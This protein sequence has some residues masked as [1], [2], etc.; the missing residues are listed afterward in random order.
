[1]PVAKKGKTG[2]KSDIDTTAAP[3]V[4]E[5]DDMVLNKGVQ[6]L[7]SSA[8]TGTIYVGYG[9]TITADSD[10]A[11]D[12]FPLAPGAAFFFP[13]R[14]LRDVWVISS[15]GSSQKIWFLAQ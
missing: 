2:R 1:M 11:T 14:H 10:D 6:V 12:G 8:N 3:L 4:S 5:A 15:T 9:D 13:C 7:T